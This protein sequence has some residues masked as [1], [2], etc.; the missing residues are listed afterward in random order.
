I[1]AAGYTYQDYVKAIVDFA[2]TNGYA[3]VRYDLTQMGTG[4]TAYLA[5]N[6]HPNN[7]GYTI[8]ASAWGST[9]GIRPNSSLPLEKINAVDGSTFFPQTASLS[10]SLVLRDVNGNFS[11]GIIT[12]ALTGNASTATNLATGRT[13][14][15]TGD[16]TYTSPSFNGSTNVTAAFTL[17]IVNANTGSFGTA[18]NVPTYTVN[19]KGLLTASANTPIQ[20]SESQVTN[21]V[22]DLAAKQASIPFGAGVQPALAVN[23]G[24]AG[25]PILFN[26]VAGTPSSIGLA[27]ATGT[28]SALSIGG[29]ASNITAYTINQNLGT[30]NSPRFASGS[31][32]TGS[33]PGALTWDITNNNNSSSFFIWQN[34]ASGAG[35]TNWANNSVLEGSN[36]VVFG[37]IGG[38][39]YWQHN[40]VGI[41]SLDGS[42]N[43]GTSGNISAPT[44]T[45]SGN[46][47]AAGIQGTTGNFSG[48]ISSSALI[49]AL[50]L[51]AA[52]NITAGTTITPGVFT[53][54]LLPIGQPVGA[55]AYVT[56]ALSPSYNATVVGG[57]S[58]RIPVFYNGTNWTAH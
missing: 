40:R 55:L 46:L 29:T 11:A 23:I 25:A 24:S 34:G 43:F 38:Q 42:G 9:L 12:A 41:A 51:Q 20:I 44:G 30:A 19:G 1:I 8:L 14:G 10:N 35:V 52:A 31:G 33:N 45:F 13:I 2:T 47:T 6:E 15:I 28:A 27:N 4:N 32:I 53:V 49:G 48:N 3:L 54:A 39:F 5:D 57:G 56:D 36:S 18:S 21:L 7:A 37:A 17:A 58:V 22:T 26:G 16:G 50:T